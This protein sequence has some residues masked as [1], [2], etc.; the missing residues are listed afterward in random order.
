ME[1]KRMLCGFPLFVFLFLLL[2]TGMP[3]RAAAEETERKAG[4]QFGAD[5]YLWMASIGGKT[6]GGDN[7]D[8]SFSDLLSKLKFGFMGVL[9]ARNGKWHFSTDVLY[10]KLEADNSGQLTVPDGSQLK[11][12][13]TVKVAAWVVTPAVGYSVIDTEQVRME[14]LAGARYLYLNPELELQVPGVGSR[15][16]SDSGDVWDG[17]AGI[18][19]EV[20]LSKNWYVPYYLDLGAGNSEF[21][22]QAAAGV[23]YRINKAV[24]VVATY[25]YLE[26]QFKDN[27]VLDNLHFSGPL[28]G[29]RLLF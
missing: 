24:E 22:W 12:N 16:I 15:N 27:K 14:V 1:K 10:M 8:V 21:T 13:S 29:L 17:I 25:R 9:Q 2:T 19:G 28:V 6:A 26:W 3:T 23:G 7:I 18:R 11:V 4:W 5:V 20:N